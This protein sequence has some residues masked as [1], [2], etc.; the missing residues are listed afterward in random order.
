MEGV[1]AR[2]G[3]GEH[4]HDLAVADVAGR[5][6]VLVGDPDGPVTLLDYLG[7]IQHQRRVRIPQLLCHVRLHL[8]Q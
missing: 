3:V 8:G 1:A 5:P 2:G 6:A 4:H 7:A